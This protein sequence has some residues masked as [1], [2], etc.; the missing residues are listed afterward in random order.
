MTRTLPVNLLVFLGSTLMALIILA[1]SLADLQIVALALPVVLAGG[2]VVFFRP[3]YGLLFITFFVQLDALLRLVSEDSFFTPEKLITLTALVGIVTIGFREP[4]RSRWGPR[5]PLVH[6]AV[7]FG[8]TLLTSLMFVKDL[9]FGLWSVRKLLSL[10]G[11]LY[12]TVRSVRTFQQVRLLLLCVVFASFISSSLVIA[13]YTMGT[14]LVGGSHAATVSSFEG[15][16]RSA[17]GSD[18]NPTTAAT[19]NLAGTT[20]ALILFLRQ[21]R[22]R[23]LTGPTIVVGTFA[24][25]LSFARSS[26]VVYALLAFWLFW[27]FRRHR[28]LPAALFLV[29]V[30]SIAVLPLIPQEYWARLM[31]MVEDWDKDKSITARISYNTVGAK[32]LLTHP[33]L[34]IGPGQFQYYYADPEYRFIPA[35]RLFVTRQLHNMYLEVGTENGFVGLFLFVAMIVMGGVALDRVRKYGATQEIRNYGE[36][37]HY[38]YVGFMTVSVFMP[39]EYNKYVWI[40]IGLAVAFARVTVTRRDGRTVPL[41]A[42]GAV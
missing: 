23:I 35:Q 15:V 2:L 32:L 14:T 11:L 12:L 36:A 5:E 30:V 3:F 10:L 21:K 33:V 17:G 16:S 34:G 9:E 41:P 31:T 20:L 8:L 4:K 27:K 28:L 19:M 13:D 6:L 39:N 40:F 1:A 38:A 29:L 37:F 7:M 25:I 26:A 22:W 24:I 18:Y 42:A